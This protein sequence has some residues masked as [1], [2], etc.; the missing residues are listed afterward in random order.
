MAEGGEGPGNKLNWFLRVATAV[1]FA[2][3]IGGRESRPPVP[4]VPQNNEAKVLDVGVWASAMEICG[5][6]YESI[7]LGNRPA[8][9]LSEATKAQDF[10]APIAFDL[11]SRASGFGEQDSTTQAG[12]FSYASGEPKLDFPSGA[13]TYLG[14][15]LC[16]GSSGEYLQIALDQ[17]DP[18]FK[19]DQFNVTVTTID[20]PVAIKISPVDFAGWQ[21][22]TGD[23]VWIPLGGATI[24]GTPKNVFPG[25]A[26]LDKIKHIEATISGGDNQID[27]TVNPA[28]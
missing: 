12:P 11:T 28:K 2:A 3:G 22:E 27:F 5:E 20:G 21:Q 14:I 13:S 8:R 19:P 10:G 4:V 24:S 23:S 7:A 18:N 9:G 1:G 6:G 17:A 16:Q 15:N 26:N 25:V